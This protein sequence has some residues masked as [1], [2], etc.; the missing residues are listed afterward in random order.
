MTLIHWSPWL[1]VSR[2]LEGDRVP[3]EVHQLARKAVAGWIRETH[4]NELQD[5]YMVGVAIAA[6]RSRWKSAAFACG[7]AVR[8]GTIAG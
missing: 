8:W 7:E 3:L 2:R 5:L 4:F 1:F 6:L